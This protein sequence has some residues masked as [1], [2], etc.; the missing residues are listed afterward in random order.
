MKLHRWLICCVVVIVGY[1]CLLSA[2]QGASAQTASVVPPLVNFSGKALDAAGKPLAGIAGATFAIYAEQ[3]GGAPL[4]ME[5]QNIQADAKGNYSVQLGATSADGLPLELFASGQARWLGVRFDGGEEQPRVLLLSVPY[6]L[7]AADAETIGGLPPSAFVLA[8]PPSISAATTSSDTSAAASSPATTSD[9]TT[10]GGTVNA[11]PLFTTA[12]NIQN[13]I[14]TQTGTTAINVVGKLNFPALGTA[15]SSAGFNSR[16]Q[17]FVASV[18]NS[19]TGT[20]VPQTFQWQAEPL[21][22]DKSTATGTLHLLYATGTNTPAETGLKISS[23]GLLTFAPGQAFPGGTITGSETVSGNISSS[24]QLISTVATG[25]APLEVTSTTEV[26][27]LNA[28]LLGGKAASAF[29][30]LASNNTFTGKQTMTGTS[31]NGVLQVT[32]TTT[33]GPAPAIV[34]TTESSGG[35]GVKGVAPATTGTAS[36][37]YGVGSSIGGYGVQGQSVNVGVY[38]QSTDT[39][40]SYTDVGVYGQASGAS[41]QSNPPAGVWGDTGGTSDNYVGVLGTADDNIAGAFVNDSGSDNS[42]DSTT[43]YVGNTSSNSSSLMFV[44]YDISTDTLCQINVAA[45]LSCSGTVSGVVPAGGD[46]RKVMVHAMQSPENWFEDFGSGTLANGA[47]TVALDPTFASTV[48]TTTDYHVFLTPKGDCK[49]LYVTNET[50][51]G[52]E[53]RE[54]GGGQSSVA[55]DYRIVAKRA[56]Y[57]NQRL[58]DVT[59]HYHKMQEDQRL[60]RE[61]MQQRRAARSGAALGEQAVHPQ[62]VTARKSDGQ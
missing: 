15:T 56:G 37:V 13:S 17:D 19:S 43:L 54:L 2:Q 28:S 49:G 52:F 16:P 25:T 21:N 8:A 61:R 3:S 55:F 41:S 62:L 58:E 57:E 60:R 26:A 35:A 6:A 24:G 59:E 33:G 34:G 32:N 46:T 10:T 1:S 40:D 14:L 50:A 20:A 53:V 7:K 48:N 27:N 44:A 4:W 5:T 11:F 51:K 31:V 18:F 22:N 47:V 12:T 42:V 29:A 36:A 38:G 39:T 30:T 23:E 9:V 45:D